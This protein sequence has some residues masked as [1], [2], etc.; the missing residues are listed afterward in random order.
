MCLDKVGIDGCGSSIE[1]VEV[2]NV[3]IFAKC[4]V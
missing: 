4:A 2:T 1:C 3:D